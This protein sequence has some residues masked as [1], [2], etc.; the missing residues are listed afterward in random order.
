MMDAR[1]ALAANEPPIAYQILAA[2]AEFRRKGT[3][4]SSLCWPAEELERLAMFAIDAKNKLALAPAAGEPA[5]PEPGICAYKFDSMVCVADLGHEGSHVT[6]NERF[7]HGLAIGGAAAPPRAPSAANRL[8]PQCGAPILQAG[9]WGPSNLKVCVRCG[10]P[11]DQWDRFLVDGS[12]PPVAGPWLN[13][14][15]LTD[16]DIEGI[17][18]RVKSPVKASNVV[19]E[20]RGWLRRLAAGGRT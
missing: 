11:S 18:Y 17:I 13:V 4:E 8:C 19:G 20:I 14:D 2:I 3:L 6:S 15:A 10:A 16:Q 12:V 5:A 9:S 7:P 1:A